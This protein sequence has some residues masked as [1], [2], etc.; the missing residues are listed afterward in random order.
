MDGSEGEQTSLGVD[1]NVR[2]PA[3]YDATVGHP[4]LVV[5]SPATMVDPTQVEELT[6]LTDPATARGYVVAY[7][8][9]VPAADEAD[10]DDAG[11]VPEQIIARWCIDERR[12]YTT[13]QSDGGT[14]ASITG[15]FDVTNPRPAA[16]AANA[17]G[18]STVTLNGVDCPAP[19]P[20]MVLHSE[21]DSHY[22]VP[23]FGLEPSQWWADCASCT[24]SGTTL[25][26]GC[27][28]YD[29]CDDG[30]EVQYCEGSEEHNEWPPMNE[31][32]LDFFD[33]FV[34]P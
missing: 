15:M 22:P 32:I 27:V 7:L 21:N 1:Y 28:A 26:N 4:L 12:V 9:H 8:S 6:G 33:R 31:A 19:L 20:V 5:Y 30:V 23:S 10:W 29:G 34:A 13:G 24:A 17:S 14:I 18:V 2:T 16:I 25:S 3:D 11:S